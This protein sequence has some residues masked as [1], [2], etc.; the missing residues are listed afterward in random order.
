MHKANSI[1][2]SR[3]LK[4]YIKNTGLKNYL[5][6]PPFHLPIPDLSFESLLT[7][8]P[9]DYTRTKNYCKICRQITILYIILYLKTNLTT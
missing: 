9:I 2:R 3:Y 7:E 8:F 5:P 6:S 4:A 1:N